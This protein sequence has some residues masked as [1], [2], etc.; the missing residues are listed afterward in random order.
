MSQPE[1]VDTHERASTRATIELERERPRVIQARIIALHLTCLTLAPTHLP[2]PALLSL[3][4]LVYALQMFGMEAGY[5]RYFSHRAYQTSR[6]F[7]LLLALVAMSSGQRG[8]LSWA[9]THRRHH[10]RSDSLDDPHSPVVRGVW[11][12]Y[13]AW[14][15]DDRNLNPPSAQVQDLLAYPELVW[16]N[17]HHAKLT[18][19]LMGALYLIGEH[20][21]LLGAPGQGLS[22]LLWG[23]LAPSLLVLHATMWVN[24]FAHRRLKEGAPPPEPHSGDSSRNL[25]WLALI[26]FGAGWHRNHHAYMSAARAG[27]G[28]RQP[29]VS[30]MLLKL[31]AKLRV[32]W[33]L[34]GFPKGF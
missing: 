13:F 32:V 10:K 16:L 25:L 8:V 23:G 5:H 21:T 9:A 26:T 19:A 33:G 4:A 34:R 14:I 31:L 17:Y 11:Y 30:Y 12:A 3:T 2:S 22:L 28:W 6:T 20:T 18:Y 27:R 29:D 1:R 7:Q 15:W 24:A